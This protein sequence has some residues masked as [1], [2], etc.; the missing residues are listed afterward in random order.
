MSEAVDWAMR[1]RQM[2]PSQVAQLSILVED[3]R[4]LAGAQVLVP[5]Q[6]FREV[7]SQWW[8]PAAG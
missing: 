3:Y 7:L 4:T 8:A 1:Y 5:T 2:A 6:A